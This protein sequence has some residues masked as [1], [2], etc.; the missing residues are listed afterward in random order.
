M[1]NPDGSLLSYN[2]RATARG[3]ILEIVNEAVAGDLLSTHKLAGIKVARS[4]TVTERKDFVFPSFKEISL[5]ADDC[6]IS[7]WL[8]RAC[9]LRVSEALA[10]SREDFVNGGA[11]LRV[12][13][14]ANG[15]GS[16]KVA[17]KHRHA[18]E[19]RD[20]PVPAYLWEMVQDLP[21]G[22]LCS[23]QT[24]DSLY[25]VIKVSA[26]KIGIPAGFSPHSL[27][28][29]F[30]SDLLSNNVPITTVAEY[31]G[32]REIS[33]TFRVY[34]HLLPN[35]SGQAQGKHSGPWAWCCGE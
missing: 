29:A 1:V 14:Q 11:T 18:G 32:H 17:L 6:G 34:A 4:D 24:Y 23:G 26:K 33:I 2:R 22:P 8:M 30:V 21:D 12:S 5:L 9:G 7:V 13:G 19:S 31:L 16:R 25:N 20:I 15:D 28:H 27:R 10:V 3:I 35:A